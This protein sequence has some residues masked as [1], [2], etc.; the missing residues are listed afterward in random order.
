MARFWMILLIVVVG[1]AGVWGLLMLGRTGPRGGGGGAPRL[2]I[3]SSVPALELAAQRL[4]ADGGEYRT[5]LPLGEDPVG[6]SPGEKTLEMFKGAQLLIVTGNELDAW[7]VDAARRA[8]RGD[9]PVIRVSDVTVY[10]VPP[11]GATTGPAT[12][13]AAG[14]TRTEDALGRAFVKQPA[15]YTAANTP[16]VEGTELLWLDTLYAQLFINE[17]S[18][19]LQS[20]RDPTQHRHIRDR[21]MLLGNTLTSL[22]GAY[23]YR[24]GRLGDKNLCTTDNVLAPLAKRYG[25]TIQRIECAGTGETG[26]TH[27]LPVGPVEQTDKRPVFAVLVPGVDP[28][29]FKAAFGNRRVVLINPMT[30][31]T[32][33]AKP[34]FEVLCKRVLDEVYGKQVEAVGVR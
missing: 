7:A 18:V 15:P 2:V 17:L 1:F 25:L 31:S 34:D 12:K 20:L 16:A 6:F 28:A 13:P 30:D 3:V 19:R 22:H 26:Y 8:G 29:A 10:G 27:G 4:L 23:D 24:F 5:L 9:I 11:G 33:V 21:A 32:D 14:T